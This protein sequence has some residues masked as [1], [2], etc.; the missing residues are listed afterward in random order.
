[1]VIIQAVIVYRLNIL[2]VKKTG[3]PEQTTDLPQATGKLLSHKVVHVLSTI[4]KGRNQIL[5][6]V[7]IGI[8]RY[9]S[10]YHIIVTNTAI[11]GFD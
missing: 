5:N 3:V 9:K 4:D 11:R 8:H 6:L 2:L 1:M 10:N 7:V